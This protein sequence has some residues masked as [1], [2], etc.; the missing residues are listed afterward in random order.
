MEKIDRATFIV[1]GAPHTG[2]S[3]VAGTL[4]ILG[5][6]MGKEFRTP[7]TYEDID[8]SQTFSLSQLADSVYK[9]NQD[10]PKWGFKYPYSSNY[11]WALAQ[12]LTNPHV[13]IT[14]RD[15]NSYEEKYKSKRLQI[16]YFKQYGVWGAFLEMFQIPFIVTDYQ[17]SISNPEYLI[18]TLSDFCELSPSSKTV[19]KALRFNTKGTSYSMDANQQGN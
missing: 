2:T 10:H 7:Q 17:R 19:E 9:K 4:H 3:L 14:Y 6:P 12:T 8:F 15:Y 11:I 16:Q 18:N 5:I 1:A 13:I